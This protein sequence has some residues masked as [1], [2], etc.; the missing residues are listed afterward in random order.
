MIGTLLIFC[1]I[2]TNTYKGMGTSRVSRAIESNDMQ[3]LGELVY[4]D[5]PLTALLPFVFSLFNDTN[6]AFYKLG[7]RQKYIHRTNIDDY[8][9]LLGNGQQMGYLARLSHVRS[10][11]ARYYDKRTGL[12]SIHI[13]PEI[14]ASSHSSFIIPKRSP[15][16]SVFNK[17]VL[18]ILESGF[19]E[20]AL[21]SSEFMNTVAHIDRSK[22][23]FNNTFA[24][25]DNS[26]HVIK[27]ADLTELLVV[28]SSLIILSVI[29]F[30]M[31]R[32]I[33]DYMQ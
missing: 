18:N 13:I 1:L 16:I 5:L 26:R 27:M 23:S 8:M 20:Y 22:L 17:I 28:W 15:F 11:Q 30:L 21:R 3:S 25:A 7:K 4:S 6:S 24:I 14:V 32:F 19:V 29:V 2:T 12:D 9:K 33:H 31:E 10:G